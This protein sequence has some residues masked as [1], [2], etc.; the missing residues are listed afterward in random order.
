MDEHR[1]TAVWEAVKAAAHAEHAVPSIRHVVIACARALSASGAGLSIARNGGEREPIFTTDA[2]TEELEELQ[3]TLGEGP[4]ADAAIADAPTQIS[5]TTE[6]AARRR[7]PAFAPASVARGVRSVSAFPVGAGAAHFGVL[8]VYRRQTGSFR[9]AEVTDAMLF[10][11]A[12]LA[13]AVLPGDGIAPDLQSLIDA[14]AAGRRAEVHQ[15]T[16]MVAAQLGV[17]V[18]DALV[19]LRAHA[20]ATGARLIELA[21]DVVNGGVRFDSL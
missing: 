1:T 14:S 11:D 10:A 7:W 12:A 4:C 2:L 16:G 17:S 20:Y 18:T 15:A 6:E 8:S 19:A 13:L 9:P 3:I 5:D 21:R